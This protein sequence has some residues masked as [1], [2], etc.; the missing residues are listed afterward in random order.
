MQFIVSVNEEL[1][2]YIIRDGFTCHVDDLRQRRHQYRTRLLSRVQLDLEP[3]R[4]TTIVGSLYCDVVGF[5]E[6]DS[7]IQ[8]LGYTASFQVD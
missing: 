1:W 3:I 6:R 4:Q 2:S 8:D 7:A 5:E